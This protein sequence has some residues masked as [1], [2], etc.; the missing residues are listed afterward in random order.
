MRG[1]KYEYRSGKYFKLLRIHSEVGDCFGP[2]QNHSF[3]DPLN[4]TQKAVNE[5]L[6]NKFMEEITLDFL[7]LLCYN[8]KVTYT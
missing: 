1:D 4:A 3:P 2:Y 8:N 6:K 7:M 5:S